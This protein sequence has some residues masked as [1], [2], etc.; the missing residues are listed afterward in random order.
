MLSGV[1]CEFSHKLLLNILK[2]IIFAFL[3]LLC[4]ICE[5]ETTCRLIRL[6]I[7][8]L[9]DSQIATYRLVKLQL[10]TCKLFRLQFRDF[11][12]THSQM[13]GPYFRVNP[14]YVVCPLGYANCCLVHV[15]LINVN[16]NQVHKPSIHFFASKVSS[17]EF[18]S[19]RNK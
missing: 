18:F 12:L 6:A 19:G 2:Y 11:P 10:T 4:L 17:R 5:L 7:H 15:N 16:S 9:I 1:Y 13:A 14:I 8:R 3:L